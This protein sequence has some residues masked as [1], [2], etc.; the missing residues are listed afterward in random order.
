MILPSF[1]SFLFLVAS[2]CRWDCLREFFSELD[3]CAC[4]EEGIEEGIE[5]FEDPFLTPRGSLRSP[6]SSRTEPVIC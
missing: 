3:R 2:S 1:V 4:V 6:V 5:A